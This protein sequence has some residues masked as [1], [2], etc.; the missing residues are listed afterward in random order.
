MII[1][2]LYCGN[3]IRIG[4]INNIYILTN[5]KKLM[6]FIGSLTSGGAERVAVSLSKYLSINNNYQVVLVTLDGYMS[7]FY[8]LHHTVKRI[9]MDMSGATSGIGKYVKNL[10]R[11]L[12]FRRIV[13][14][15]KP[16]VVL[17]MI[18][19]HAVIS[20]LACVLLPVKV[21]VSERNYPGKRKNHSIWEMLREYTYRHA[22][23]HVVQTSKIAEWLRE[24]TNSTNIHIIP[25]SISWPL[26]KVEPNLAPSD[27]VK[28]DENIILAVGSFKE[29]KGFDLL[30]EAAAKFLKNYPKWKLVI[31]GGPVDE[32]EKQKSDYLLRQYHSMIRKYHLKEQ[33]ILPG[34]AGNVVDWYRRS[35]IFVL[36]SRYEGFPN[37][38]LE[39][40]ASGTAC[41]AFD[42][43]TGPSDL[44][45]D[46]HNGILVEESDIGNLSVSIQRLISDA[47]LRSELSKN[48]L[49][50]R[51]I[52]C[53]KIIMK[54]WYQ[55]LTSDMQEK[56]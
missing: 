1:D 41:V 32:E 49:E 48:A 27:Y 52:Y 6:I 22:D 17:G 29:Q 28:N 9:A 3:E 2:S 8:T 12:A 47:D 4:N 21:V 11:V 55:I 25:N 54:E 23:A 10:Q 40:M 44:I 34:K 16:D 46:G 37:V 33:I 5:Q 19:R 56:N 51:E 53:E 43:D 13:K 18:T 31:L 14:K 26:G 7:D 30:I 35:D 20:I 36:S 42:C 38:L 24:N 45:K 15:E 50:V 39:A